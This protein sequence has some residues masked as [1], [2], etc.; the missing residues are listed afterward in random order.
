[1]GGGHCDMCII[2][3]LSVLQLLQ[4]LSSPFS[5]PLAAPIVSIL[6]NLTAAFISIQQNMANPR[7]YHH[8]SPPTKIHPQYQPTTI[9]SDPMN[10]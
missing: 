4:V 7:T 2:G 3:L 8:N 9:Q 5:T 10:P 6:N 1:M